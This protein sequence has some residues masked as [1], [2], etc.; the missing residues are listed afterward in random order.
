MTDLNHARDARDQDAELRELATKRVKAR[1]ELY[2]HLV[3][4]LAVNTFLVVIWFATGAGFFWPLF[5]IF[6]WGIGLVLN[7]WSVYAP[8]S[9]PAQVDAE[10]ERLRRQRDRR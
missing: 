2:A 6:G 3:T 1:R 4:Y 9:T 8:E 5:I 7:A 10:M